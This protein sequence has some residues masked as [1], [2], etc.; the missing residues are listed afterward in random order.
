MSVYQYCVIISC[1][2]HQQPHRWCN[3]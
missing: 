1:E 2:Y 3:G